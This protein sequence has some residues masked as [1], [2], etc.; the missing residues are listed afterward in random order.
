MPNRAANNNKST[1]SEH[2]IEGDTLTRPLKIIVCVDA[3]PLSAKIIPHAHA[4]AD[5]LGGEL[6]LTHV[7]EFGK[8]AAFAIRSRGLGYASARGAGPC[9]PSR[10]QV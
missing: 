1:V 10:K 2:S 7:I 3:S 9:I 4:I 5:A 8:I 6:V